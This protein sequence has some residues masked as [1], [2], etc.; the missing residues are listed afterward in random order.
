MQRRCRRKGLSTDG[1]ERKFV[2]ED[3]DRLNVH[4]STR[5]ERVWVIDSRADIV[6]LTVPWIPDNVIRTSSC[7]DT[8]DG[9]IEINDGTASGSVGGVDV[10]QVAAIGG[11]F[12][13]GSS[14]AELFGDPSR[15]ANVEEILPKDLI[16]EAR[17]TSERLTTSDGSIHLE[18]GV[19]VCTG[20]YLNDAAAIKDLIVG[21]VE[22]GESINHLVEIKH[23]GGIGTASH[24][25]DARSGC[26][27]DIVLD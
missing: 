17:E 12:L 11:V 14:V 23:K 15:K 6:G 4:S 24:C 7:D 9:S 2:V 8:D 18:Y 19:V 3:T 13:K 26:D 5:T 27:N 21:V 1:N 10:G 20:F 22:P 16:F 25:C